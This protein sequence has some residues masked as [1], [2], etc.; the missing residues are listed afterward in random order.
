MEKQFIECGKIV[1]T[2]GVKGELK[3]EPWTDDPNYL[4][5]FSTL[6]LD[7]GKTPLKVVGSRIHKGML[8]LMAEGIDSIDTANQYRGK[9]LC[10]NR[11][12]DPDDSPFLIDFLGIHVLDA[13]SGKD[14]GKITNVIRTGANDVYE[15][16][17]E[18]GIE[19]LVPDIPQVVLETDF[20]TK[21]MKIRPLKGLFEDAD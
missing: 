9:V 13:D 2:H 15:L 21:V 5:E 1:S 4:L 20:A 10:I 11:A 6:Y 17:N 14:Y 18:E 7:S 16:R 3:I 19:R 8:L 12:D